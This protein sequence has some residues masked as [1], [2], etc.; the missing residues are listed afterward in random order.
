MLSK[1]TSYI[2]SFIFHPLILK[3]F[4]Y[5]V[6][7]TTRSCKVLDE[8][9]ERRTIVVYLS[10]VNLHRGVILSGNDVLGE[11]ATS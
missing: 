6:R 9:E 8:S 10:N 4:P 1:G 7:A 5:F 3:P 2:F 11:R